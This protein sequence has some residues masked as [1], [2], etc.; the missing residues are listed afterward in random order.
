MGL[1][2]GSEFTTAS[3]KIFLPKQTKSLKSTISK[4][5][6]K[7][8]TLFHFEGILDIEFFLSA[9]RKILTI[10]SS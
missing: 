1:L 3:K 7:D 8:D 9:L 5:I 6:G 10:F 2:D 4:S